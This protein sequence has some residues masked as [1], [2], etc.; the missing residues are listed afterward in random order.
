MPARQMGR[1]ASAVLTKFRLVDG[2]TSDGIC[3]HTSIEREGKKRIRNERR[4]T[5]KLKTMRRCREASS[6]IG[7]VAVKAMWARKFSRPGSQVAFDASLTGAPHL[8][9]IPDPPL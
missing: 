6:R 8:E 5:Q 3:S 4:Y 2:R 9:Q 1:T 7:V